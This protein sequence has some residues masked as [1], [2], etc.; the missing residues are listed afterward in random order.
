MLDPR[1]SE[2]YRIPELRSAFCRLVR[3]V[4]LMNHAR[5]GEVLPL[6]GF[7]G[8]GLMHIAMSFSEAGDEVDWS[9]S[10]L[11]Y[12]A[13]FSI[14]G[15]PSFAVSAE[16][17]LGVDARPESAGPA[18]PQPRKGSAWANYPNMPTGN[19]IY[20]AFLAELVAFAPP[21]PNPGG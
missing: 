14:T 19:A 5:P 3:P 4:G 11:I 15:P 12:I 9:Q 21:P 13:R 1:L 20:K 17:H 6:I 18:G 7:K 10:G 2:L 8:R 16:E